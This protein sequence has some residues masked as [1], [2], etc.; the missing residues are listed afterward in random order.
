MTDICAAGWT[1]AANPGI[2]SDRTVVSHALTP[3]SLFS[4]LYTAELMLR[5]SWVRSC[6]MHERGQLS[7]IWRR[8][9]IWLINW[10]I[11]VLSFLALFQLKMILSPSSKTSLA[12]S[13][14]KKFWIFRRLLVRFPVVERRT[15]NKDFLD[16]VDS[17]INIQ[18]PF[19]FLDVVEWN[20]LDSVKWPEETEAV[21][22]FN[23]E[24][25]WCL[26][27]TSI[28]LFFV[29]TLSMYYNVQ[30]NIHYAI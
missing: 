1:G 10:L 14:R 8:L 16:T 11:C 6:I 21:Y 5:F 26:C 29:S 24:Y 23:V 30:N 3:S 15:G 12:F 18:V 27:H 13:A 9:S 19:S 17:F 20:F 4:D 28:L 7:I 22:S 25:H 2:W